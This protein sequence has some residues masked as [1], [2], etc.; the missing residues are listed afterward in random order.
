MAII[1]FTVAEIRAMLK[2]VLPGYEAEY[3][4]IE[5]DYL[6]QVAQY[7]KRRD[8][9]Q[10]ERDAE[11]AKR[12]AR[13]REL[14][15]ED[16][17]NQED[18]RDAH[19]IR[20]FFG[21]KWKTEEEFYEE[22]KR[23]TIWGLG[24]AYYGSLLWY[25]PTRPEHTNLTFCQNLSKKLEGYADDRIVGLHPEEARILKSNENTT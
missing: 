19:P 13:L 12:E 20:S 15:A 24:R 23:T 11:P 16:F 21:G 2:S 25:F 22:R 1:H 4:A 10:A 14:A 8:E 18:W 5:A 17:K 7:K 3:A 6:E 9:E